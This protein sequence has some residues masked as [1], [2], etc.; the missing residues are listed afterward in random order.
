MG[1]FNITMEQPCWKFATTKGSQSVK[2]P[3]DIENSLALLNKPGEWFADF[4]QG[5]IYYVPLPGQDAA[6]ISAVLGTEAPPVPPPDLTA[7]YGTAAIRV[8]PGAQNLLFSGI[9]V[10]H[11]TWNQ[12]SGPGGFVDLQS[13]FFA[14]GGA[15]HGVPGAMWMTGVKN[16]VITDC[17]FVHLG[18]SGIVADG[19][20][21]NINV[22]LSTFTDLSGSAVSVGNVSDP[23]ATPTTQDQDFFIDSNQISFTGQEY[24]GCAG[25]FAGYVAFTSI[26]HNAISDTSNGA[27]C[28]GWGWGANNTM[29]Q[30]SVSYNHIT[31]SNTVLYD[32]GSIYTLSAQP[33]SEVRSSENIPFRVLPDSGLS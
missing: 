25:V 20:S 6:S 1:T 19:G 32:C 28:I 14:T 9:T 3:S 27:V 2:F 10:T 31:R 5:K 4:D 7:D 17:S 26:V 13:G 22:T 29:Q 15:L 8:L 23:I 24:R 21:Q 11:I 30:N 12:P 33:N 18:L 16:V